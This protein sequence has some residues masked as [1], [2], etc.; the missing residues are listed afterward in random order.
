MDQRF[1]FSRALFQQKDVVRRG[2]IH[3][4][5]FY[6]AYSATTRIKRPTAW[7]GRSATASAVAS[8]CLPTTL[9]AAPVRQE[10]FA[11]AG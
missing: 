3:K 4:P 11:I 5:A 6:Q 7:S 10:H 2:V 8:R 1:L 9:P